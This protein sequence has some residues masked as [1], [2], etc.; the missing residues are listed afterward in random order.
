MR[1][2]RELKQTNPN[3]VR[4]LMEIALVLH[5]EPALVHAIREYADPKPLTRDEFWPVLLAKVKR[6]WGE[7]RVEDKERWFKA[8]RRDKKVR[9]E[10]YK[11]SWDLTSWQITVIRGLVIK[12]YQ[13]QEE[14]GQS[15]VSE[16]LESKNISNQELFQKLLE[17][18]N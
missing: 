2:L 18:I 17:E 5:L 4:S 9:I 11:H 12:Q 10:A 7:D 6:V 3:Y 15:R 13:V 1:S 8:Q 16:D 14:D